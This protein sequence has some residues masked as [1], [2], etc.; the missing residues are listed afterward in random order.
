MTRRDWIASSAG[1]LLASRTASAD[2]PAAP[3][4][5]ARCQTYGPELVTTLNTMFDQLGGLGR[6]VAGKS[7]AIK[8]NLTGSPKDR[9]GYVPAEL[10]HWTHPSVIGATIHLMNRAGAR[11]VR[12]LESCWSTAEP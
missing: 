9:L 2:A 10:A 8:I 6:L 4:A 7:V 5:V 3:V 11:R 1:A 12:L